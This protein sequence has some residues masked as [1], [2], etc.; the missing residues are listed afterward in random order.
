[1]TTELIKDYAA[2]VVIGAL[3]GGVGSVIYEIGNTSYDVYDLYQEIE[4]EEVEPEEQL[5]SVCVE[6]INDE[7]KKQYFQAVQH[8]VMNGIENSNQVLYNL[9][10]FAL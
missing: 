6:E 7:I 1:M 9:I 2:P 3:T 5:L 8:A 4:N 10:L